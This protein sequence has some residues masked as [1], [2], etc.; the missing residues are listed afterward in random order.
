MKDKV[1]YMGYCT[2]CYYRHRKE[3]PENK[4]KIQMQPYS[5]IDECLTCKKEVV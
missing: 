4:E 3:N 5:M 2:D 1:A